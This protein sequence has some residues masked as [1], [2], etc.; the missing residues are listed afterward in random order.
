MANWKKWL[1][2]IA[3]VLA[4]VAGALIAWLDGDPATTPDV[5]GTIK[6]VQEGVNVIRAGEEPATQGLTG[7]E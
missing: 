7:K 6:Q 2:G 5:P 4:A 1:L 3:L